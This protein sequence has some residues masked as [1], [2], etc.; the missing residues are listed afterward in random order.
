[1][2]P[3][4]TPLHERPLHPILFALLP[5][6]LVLAQNGLEI[7]PGD[8]IRPLAIALAATLILLA[9]LSR[10]LRNGLQAALLTT[11]TIGLF[12]AY[13]RLY[14][15]N[16]HGLLQGAVEAAGLPGHHQRVAPFVLAMWLVTGW[17]A[18]RLHAFNRHFTTLLNVAGFSLIAGALIAI[19]HNEW[20]INQPWPPT[21]SPAMPA[22][23]V[24]DEM[25]ASPSH[26]DDIYYLV[27]DGYARDDVLA[28]L[29]AYDNTPLL[30]WLRDRGFTVIEEAHSNYNQ[31]SLSLAA[32]LN[33]TYLDE[34]TLP[35]LRNSSDRTPLVRMIR[36]SA[37]ERVLRNHGYSIISLRGGYRPGY[38][39]GD[40]VIRTASAESTLLERLLIEN[41]ALAV[42]ELFPALP[43]ALLHP[44]YPRHRRR[45]QEQFARLP[46]VKKDD[47]PLFVYAHILVPHPPF[48]FDAEGRP[49]Q[50][51]YPYV[52]LDG[53]AFP[54]ERSSYR[55][56][57]REQLVFVNSQLEHSLADLIR[58]QGDSAWIVIQG[59]HG[60]GSGL[61][62]D[63]MEGTNLRERFG[64]VLAY[65][66]PGGSGQELGAF[67]SPVNLFRAL[68]QS[69]LE[70][71]LALHS[72]RA[73]F[74]TWER[75]YSFELVPQAALERTNL[76]EGGE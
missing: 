6:L 25:R 37:L 27:L 62:W 2:K 66:P 75:P 10:S 18:R 9:S 72:D 48:V 12:S 41:S 33:M 63:S 8:A 45:V 54:G 13:G 20:Q 11:L 51:S 43:D 40:R 5:T 26:S 23:R 58:S 67:R 4:S 74:S 22:S 53:N 47:S 59:D 35:G 7:P 42:L 21:T 38:L 1:M 60:P 15:G 32:T 61:N 17:A 3:A 68:L 14:T 56:R 19:G 30:R 24:G 31:T 55:R 71:P 65:R 44:A 52:L 49:V 36:H 29:Y 69:E 16:V 73:Y 34:R 64:I 39:G 70:L 50:P 28:D 76:S 46:S 57:Y